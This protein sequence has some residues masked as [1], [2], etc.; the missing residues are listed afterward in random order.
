M[1]YDSVIA[2][3]D[4]QNRHVIIRARIATRVEEIAPLRTLHRHR[5]LRRGDARIQLQRTQG[6]HGRGLRHALVQPPPSPRRYLTR[7]GLA[8]WLCEELLADIPTIVGVDHGFSFP[9]AYFEKYRLPCRCK[10]WRN[11]C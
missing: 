5:L 1:Q 6:V 4:E 10:K 3:V 11:R 7:R 2:Q 9:L 8:E